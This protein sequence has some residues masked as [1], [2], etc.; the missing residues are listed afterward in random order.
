VCAYS[1]DFA[2][3]PSDGRWHKRPHSEFGG[4]CELDYAL[5]SYDISDMADVET[6]IAAYAKMQAELEAKHTGKW[7]L[8]Y[9][10][11][12][13]SIHDSFETAAEEAVRCFG[14]GPYLIRQ[15]GAPPIT[16]PAS[17]MFH[18]NYG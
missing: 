7:V 10:G 16:L 12:L 18:V 17:V 5:T 2:S 13:I 4:N 1:S 6:E 14:R 8:F 11:S 15:V 3:D 9:G